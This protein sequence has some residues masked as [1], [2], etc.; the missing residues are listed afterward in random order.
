MSLTR[1]G[2]LT[3]RMMER[4]VSSM[5]STRTWVTPPREPVRPRTCWLAMILGAV[6]DVDETGRL[7]RAGGGWTRANSRTAELWRDAL[8]FQPRHFEDPAAERANATTGE[9]GQRTTQRQRQSLARDEGQARCPQPILRP[10]QSLAI[11]LP[12]VY[13]VARRDSSSIAV[14]SHPSPS[15]RTA[16]AVIVGSA[17]PIGRS[18]CPSRS[19]V[20]LLS[21]RLSPKSCPS[22][23]PSP[24]F[25][26]LSSYAP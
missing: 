2:P 13:R 10:F 20:I 24:P 7:G 26:R 6:F 21:C 23:R 25:R 4:E 12:H 18:G 22:D 1:T 15:A 16:V 5:N 9:S 3:L 17:L 19:S 8:K 11:S 14:A